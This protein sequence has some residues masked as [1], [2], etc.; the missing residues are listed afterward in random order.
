MRRLGSAAI[1]VLIAGC[2]GQQPVAETSSTTATT[3]PIPSTRNIITEGLH[4]KRVGQPGGFGCG[5]GPD[6]VCDVTFTV[7]AIDQNPLCPG[8][9]PPSGKQLLRIEVDAEAPRPFQYEPSATALMLAH[10]ATESGDGVLQNLEMVNACS[11]DAGAFVGPLAPATHP[12]DS[13]VVIAPRGA[14]FLWLEYEKT[15]YR[16]P[17]RPPV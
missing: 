8:V 3:E 4:D 2:G 17:V 16:W 15:A 7:T 12:R 9:L 5:D 6:A 1:L 10:W 13:A 14:T 11:P